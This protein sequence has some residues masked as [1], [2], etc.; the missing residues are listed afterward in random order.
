MTR[1][2]TLLPLLLATLAPACGGDGHD[3]GGGNEG[4]VITTVV[5]TFTPEA[6]GDPVVAAFD[7]P[8]GD[9]GDP[10]TVD[11]IALPADAS[12]ALAVAFENRLES[13]PEDI[14][15]E[16]EDEGDEHQV[17]F[18]GTAIDTSDAAIGPLAHAYADED[19]GGLPIGLVNR[20]VTF[21]NTGTLTVTLRHLPPVNGVPVKVA[22][23]AEVVATDGLGAIGGDTDAQVSF[24]V[25]VE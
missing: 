5:L 8:D 11:A 1:P 20:V 24:E 19:L 16:V 18:T 7:D 2:R 12:F 17:F 13:P 21:P 3:H 15:A 22:G 4:E 10:P 23:L 9:G 14:T 25:T 6:G